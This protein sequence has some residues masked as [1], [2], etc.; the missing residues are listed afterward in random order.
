MTNKL[1]CPKCGGEVLDLRKFDEWGYYADEPK[2]YECLGSQ[3]TGEYYAPFEDVD[4]NVIEVP[5]KTQSCGE[6]TFEEVSGG[7][8]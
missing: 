7:E 2:H 6:F 3:P 8:A 1:K 5:I 4:G